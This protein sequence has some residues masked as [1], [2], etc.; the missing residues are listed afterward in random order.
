MIKTKFDFDLGLRHKSGMTANEFVRRYCEV[1][2]DHAY[3]TPDDSINEFEKLITHVLNMLCYHKRRSAL[4]GMDSDPRSDV[5][6]IEDALSALIE[7]EN[8]L[9]EALSPKLKPL[10]VEEYRE[11]LAASLTSQKGVEQ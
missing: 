2:R 3:A 11:Q 10:V 9:S 7:A 1:F 5:R 6:R 8:N 4:L